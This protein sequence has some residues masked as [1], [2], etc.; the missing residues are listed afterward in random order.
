MVIPTEKPRAI[1]LL[2][3][4]D[5]DG[6]SEQFQYQNR[7]LA[8]DQFQWQSQNRTAQDSKNGRLLRDH[9]QLGVHVHLFIRAEK[10]R[11]GA[12]AAFLYCGT[13]AFEK[14]EGNEPITVNWRL[15]QPL[16]ERLV[17]EFAQP[18][19]G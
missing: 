15:Q 19:S 5:R 1:C 17:A 7:F 6:M 11:S 10:K 4:I 9:Q 2:V 8:P 12:P 16:P 3:T 13:V 14:W 18:Q